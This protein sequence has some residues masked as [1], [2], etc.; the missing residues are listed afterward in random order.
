M[1][2]YKF[3]IIISFILGLLFFTGCANEVLPNIDSGSSTGKMIETELSLNFD[4]PGQEIRTR[5]DGFG[6]TAISKLWVGIYDIETGNRVGAKEFTSPSGSISMPV[7]YYDDHPKVVIVGVANYDF[8]GVFLDWDGK[9]IGQLLEKAETWNDFLNISLKCPEK[10]GAPV[11]DM[12]PEYNQIMMG[13]VSTADSGR[14]FLS[15]T[16]EGSVVISENASCIVTLS[17]SKYGPM[18]QDLEYQKLYLYPLYAQINVS[19]ISGPNA[20]VTN[21][22]YRRCNL[23]KGVFL[24]ERPVY[25]GETKNWGDWS[26][27]QTPNFADTKMEADDGRI[28]N[29][30][31]YYSDGKEE[32][33]WI[34]AERNNKFTFYQY[35]NKHWGWNGYPN[36]H[37]DRERLAS[38]EDYPATLGHQYNSF[39]SYF[40]IRMTILDKDKSYNTQHGNKSAEIEYVVHQGNCNDR[41]GYLSTNNGKDYCVF[42]N[43]MYNYKINVNGISSITTTVTT[44]GHYDGMSG[45]VWTADISNVQGNSWTG[46]YSNMNLTRNSERTSNLIIRFY[47]GRGLEQ[48]PLDYIIS[49]ELPEDLDLNGM[50]W[51]MIDSNT[52]FAQPE[53]NN[54]ITQRFTIT[55]TQYSY[56]LH[57]CYSYLNQGGNFRVDFKPPTTVEQQYPDAYK[58]GIYYYYASEKTNLSGSDSDECTNFT[59]KICHVIEWKPNQLTIKLNPINNLTSF[60]EQ[61][62]L[63]QSITID[64]NSSNT[65]SN[66]TYGVDYKYYLKLYNNNNQ[67]GEDI[68]IGSDLIY[69][70]NLDNLNYDSYTYGVYAKSL[71]PTLYSDSDESWNRGSINLTYPYWDFDNYSSS[72]NLKDGYNFNKLFLVDGQSGC[73]FSA[74]R[75]FG[76]SQNGEQGVAMGGKGSET[77]RYFYMKIYKSCWL[78]INYWVN[79]SDTR[80]V[81]VKVGDNDPV[82]DPVGSNNAKTDNKIYKRTFQTYINASGE[83][84]VKIYCTEGDMYFYEIGLSN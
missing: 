58:M 41:W 2:I 49:G 70:L 32:K 43:M 61:K 36:G 7:I 33:D 76:D 50:Y 27:F 51:P 46:Y 19:I 17:D 60:T 63:T 22:S 9:P 37:A 39:A 18:H 67:V 1:K 10:D 74:E 83:T 80:H 55:D 45:V 12:N 11:A 53:E 84:M 15:S 81:S 62:F 25:T 3:H 13:V 54:E 82:T 14:P 44:E 59:N 71:D 65:N 28:V 66:R 16:K 38:G 6:S 72:I 21:V 26:G 5:A 48:P 31:S 30:D 68:E 52:V 56:P 40:V 24:A 29:A 79:S 8:N 69:T 42:R 4:T 57:Y 20:E 23:P 34:P 75:T 64:L 77:Q 73:N 47:V 35:E 78:S